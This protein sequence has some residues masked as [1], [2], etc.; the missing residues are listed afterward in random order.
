M[1]PAIIF[2]L[3][4]AV[5]IVLIV[6][7]VSFEKLKQLPV[8]GVIQGAFAVFTLV[9]SMI[10][11]G[12]QKLVRMVFRKRDRTRLPLERSAPAPLDEKPYPRSDDSFWSETAPRSDGLLSNFE[13]AEK[14]MKTGKLE[15]AEEL[16]LKA[17]TK[18]PRDARI[19]SSLGLIYL[20]TRSFSDAIEAFKVAVR[21]DKYNPSRH[22]NLAVAYWGNKD[23]QRAIASIHEAIGL[24]PVTDK[25][26]QFLEEL[27]NSK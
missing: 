2:F 21:L 10:A 18:S 12:I 3:A 20:E 15:Q 11:A 17:A 9:M 24:D 27:L 8:R 5:F 26:R 4:V 23:S 1:T 16:F 25:Y 22:Y 13:E 14:L 19:Y 6:R 7:H